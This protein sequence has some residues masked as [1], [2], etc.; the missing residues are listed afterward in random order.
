MKIISF[1]LPIRK[2][3]IIYFLLILIQIITVFF[4][5]VLEKKEKKIKYNYFE[6]YLITCFG[7]I[8]FFVIIF[9]YKLFF[10]I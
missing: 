5:K 7:N 8:L 2:T 4:I 10:L 6:S 9:F 3:N 1:N